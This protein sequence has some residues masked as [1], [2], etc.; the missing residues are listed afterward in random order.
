MVLTKKWE[1]VGLGVGVVKKPNKQKQSLGIGLPFR[2]V[3]VINILPQAHKSLFGFAKQKA[4][5]SKSPLRWAWFASSVANGMGYIS[6]NSL[7]SRL[8]SIKDLG[9]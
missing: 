5:C 3:L 8:L 9:A 7:N 6:D 4:K 1:K 2:L